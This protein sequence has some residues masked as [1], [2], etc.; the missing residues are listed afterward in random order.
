MTICPIAI[1]VGCKK[2]PAFKFCPLTTVLGDQQEED[3]VD[4]SPMTLAHD[5]D[6]SEA[7]SQKEIPYTSDDPDFLS[8]N[9]STV[10][11]KSKPK[12]AGSTNTPVDKIEDEYQRY[13]EEELEKN[14]KQ[15]ESFKGEDAEVIPERKK[16]TKDERLA[17]IKK[18]AEKKSVGKVDW[19][20]EGKE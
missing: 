7:I 6:W 12:S 2:C 4:A 5:R 9:R 19:L 16:L 17:L 10:P 3:E 13:A 11:K 18:S 14:T 15:M 8:T 20:L 1:A